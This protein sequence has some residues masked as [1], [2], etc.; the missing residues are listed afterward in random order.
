[1]DVSRS[2]DSSW[3]FVEPADCVAGEDREVRAGEDHGIEAEV[4]VDE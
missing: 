2:S 4:L 3:N 1:M